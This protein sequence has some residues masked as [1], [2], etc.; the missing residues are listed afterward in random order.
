[1]I[2]PEQVARLRVAEPPATDSAGSP[3]RELKFNK[4]PVSESLPSPRPV[5]MHTSW[6]PAGL[7]AIP[8]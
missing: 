4:R 5:R 3:D 2:A 8:Q 7:W 1:M 6:D